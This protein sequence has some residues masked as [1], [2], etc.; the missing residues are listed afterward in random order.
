M[1]MSSSSSSNDSLMI[2]LLSNWMDDMRLSL[3][4]E[5]E[6]MPMKDLVMLTS[7]VSLKY[8]VQS[9][10]LSE[11][12]KTNGCTLVKAPILIDTTPNHST[13]DGLFPSLMSNLRIR[14][15]PTIASKLPSKFLIKLTNL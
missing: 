13:T 1:G 7:L 5:E 15:L 2:E 10:I 3:E 6:D 11:L 4:E 12:V 14:L 8:S 9:T